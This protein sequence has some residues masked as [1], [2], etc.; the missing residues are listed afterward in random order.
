MHEVVGNFLKEAKT[1]TNF[2]LASHEYKLEQFEGTSCRGSYTTF[3][4]NGFATGTL[5]V[6]FIMNVGSSIWNGQFTGPSEAWK[7]ALTVLKTVKNGG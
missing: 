6:I 2:S 4:I 3:E 7:Q 1:S 5:Q